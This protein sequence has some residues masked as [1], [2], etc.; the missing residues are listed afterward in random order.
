MALNH[1][2][3]KK[4]DKSLSGDSTEI[5][6]VDFV[7]E[8]MG[9]SSMDELTLQFPRVAELPFDSDRKCMTTVHRLGTQ[10]IIFSK[11]AV[12]YISENWVSAL[13]HLPYS[14]MR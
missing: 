12:E 2:V 11:G 4:N 8:K 6:L 1:D 7:I 3:K 5:A 9:S 14:F 13:V 10:Y